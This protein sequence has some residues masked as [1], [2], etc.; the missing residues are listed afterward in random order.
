MLPSELEETEVAG[1]KKLGW[2]KM[3]KNSPRNCALSFSVSFNWRETPISKLRKP[4]P[5]IAFLPRLPKVPAGAIC[6]AGES[7]ERQLERLPLARMVHV[8]NQR[9]GDGL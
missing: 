6:Q 5:R 2:F 7:P 9:V 1:R 8:L 3:L 4:G